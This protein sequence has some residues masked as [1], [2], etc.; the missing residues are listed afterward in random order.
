MIFQWV[1]LHQFDL[2]IPCEQIE[3]METTLNDCLWLQIEWIETTLN[4][5]LWLQI[6]WIEATLNVCLGAKELSSRQLKDAEAQP[7]DGVSAD[8]AC[9]ACGGGTIAGGTSSSEQTPWLSMAWV[10]L[11]LMDICIDCACAGGTCQDTDNGAVDE[12]GDACSAYRA[13]WCYTWCGGYDDSDFSS[14]LM[15][16]ACSG[17]HDVRMFRGS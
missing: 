7:S 11:V 1:E 14:N 17:P 12:Y 9:C 8:M 16:C 10:N 5:C 2:L 15:C 13:T 4:F 6:K 3:L